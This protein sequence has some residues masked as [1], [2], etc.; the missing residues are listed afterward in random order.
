MFPNC[1][2]S[3]E[4]QK[5]LE[6][7]FVLLWK[8]DIFEQEI[9]SPYNLIC[10]SLPIKEKGKTQIDRRSILR[11]FRMHPRQKL[12]SPSYRVANFTPVYQGHL[13]QK[14]AGWNVC[15]LRKL[16]SCAQGVTMQSKST[17][18]FQIKFVQVELR[19]ADRIL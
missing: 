2:S 14:V 17:N 19:A 7:F 12:T 15:F 1:H 16:N 4:L 13:F 8:S 9:M 3:N 18:L 5:W 11:E 10:N 6:C